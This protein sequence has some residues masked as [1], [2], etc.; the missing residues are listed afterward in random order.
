MAYKPVLRDCRM[1]RSVL[2]Y[3]PCDC[4]SVKNYV[5][6]CC[7]TLTH[8]ALMCFEFL[9]TSTITAYN[10]GNKNTPTQYTEQYTGNNYT[11]T[12]YTEQYR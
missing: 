4:P 5:E 3:G 1:L 10:T 2:L 6:A 11:P 7:R 8:H 12:Q 9:I